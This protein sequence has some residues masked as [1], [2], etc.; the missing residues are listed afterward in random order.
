MTRDDWE[1]CGILICAALLFVFIG[2]ATAL[3][4]DWL[5]GVFGRMGAGG[6]ATMWTAHITA[7]LVALTA[8]LSTLFR[9]INGRWW[10][11]V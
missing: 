3:F 4:G 8:T 10:W 1:A 2:A 9:V 5:W 6:A 7:L 11:N